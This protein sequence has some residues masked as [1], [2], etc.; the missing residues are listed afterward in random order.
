MGRHILTIKGGIYKLSFFGT[1]RYFVT[2]A[3][4]VN[5]LC[6]EKRFCKSTEGALE[7]LR[8]GTGAGLF[9]AR[10]QEHDWEV[11]HRALVPA[12]GPMGIKDMFDEMH[13]IASQ[14]V[15]KWARSGDEPIDVSDNYTRLTLDSIALCAMGKRFN[16]FYSKEMHP[17]V[18]AMIGFLLEGGRRTRRSRLEALLNPSYERNFQKDIQIMKKTAEEVVAE[19]RANPTDK[20]DLLNAVLFGKDPKTGEKLSEEN[21]INN[22]ITFLVA[23]EFTSLLFSTFFFLKKNI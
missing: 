12:F 15:S 14:L 19:R 1:E 21:M 23:G 13:D 5:E 7:E 22:I 18:N 3:A 17:F 8:A 2:S 9:T 6:D 16:S 20:K 11:A 10:H 4:I